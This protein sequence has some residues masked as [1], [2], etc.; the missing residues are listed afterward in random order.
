VYTLMGSMNLESELWP[1]VEDTIAATPPVNSYTN[2]G[3]NR[4]EFYRVGVDW[5]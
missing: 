2:N 4:M 1:V 5:E 3:T